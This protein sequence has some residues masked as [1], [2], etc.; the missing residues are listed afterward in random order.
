MTTV[1]ARLGLRRMRP[2]DPQEEHRA[3]SPLELFFDLVFVVAVSQAAVELHHA[4]S[5]G[6][7][8]SGVGAY[9]WCSSRSGGHG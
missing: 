4:E 9:P 2:R 6:H 3:A 5:A 1:H 8:A 7:I